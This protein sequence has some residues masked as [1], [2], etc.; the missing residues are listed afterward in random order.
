MNKEKYV[1]MYVNPKGYYKYLRAIE[2]YALLPHQL[3]FVEM[4]EKYDNCEFNVN[5]GQFEFTNNF[6][7]FCPKCGYETTLTTKFKKQL[8][9]NCGTYIKPCGLCDMDKVDCNKCILES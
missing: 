4:Y 9:K 3:Q 2:G 8:C 7:E 5:T 6:T 1:H